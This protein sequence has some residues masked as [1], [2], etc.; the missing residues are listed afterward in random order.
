MNEQ[1]EKEELNIGEAGLYTFPFWL[2]VDTRTPMLG[3]ELLKGGSLIRFY[4]PFRSASANFMPMPRIR[5][6]AVPFLSEVKPNSLLPMLH[7]VTLPIFQPDGG[8]GTIALLSDQWGEKPK[9]FPMDSLRIDL[10]STPNTKR[11]F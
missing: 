2:Y 4:P 3:R 6:E 9:I 8:P 11:R 10:F 1:I 5:P 7:V